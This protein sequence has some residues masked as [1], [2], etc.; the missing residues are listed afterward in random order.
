MKRVGFIGA[1]DKSDLIIY[2]AKLLTVANKSVLIIDAST[3]QKTKYIVPTISPAKAYVT[4]FENIDVAVGFYDYDSIKEYLGMPLSAVFQYDYI[5]IDVDS[6][7]DFEGFDIKSA[8]KNFFVTGFDVY[9]I[10]RGKEILSDLLEPVLFTKVFFSRN[11]YKE[12]EEYFDNIFSDCKAMW[13]DEIIYF[14]FEQG[15]QSIIMENQRVSKIK[16]KRLTKFYKESLLYISQK[17]ADDPKED[18]NLKKAFKL[19]EKELK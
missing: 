16:F 19:L 9:S 7:E 11:I 6:P 12:E 4:N 17:I 18:A 10:K 2:I 15:D 13:N 5:F 3:L 8:D 14:P 1:Y